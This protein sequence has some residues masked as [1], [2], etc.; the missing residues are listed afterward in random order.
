MAKRGNGE[1]SIYRRADGRWVASLSYVDDAGKRKRCTVYGRTR[2]E[3]SGRLDG[4][5]ER[6]VRGEPLVD[7]AVTVHDWLERWL[8]TSVAASDR[9]PSTVD[10]YRKACHLYI[11]PSL[12][13]RQLGQLKPT[14][15]EHV[16]LALSTRGKSG[17]TRRT[18]YNVLRSALNNG[19][20]DGLVRSN[21]V[22][23]YTGC[24]TQPCRGPDTREPQGSGLL[25]CGLGAPAIGLEP[26]TCRLTAGCSAN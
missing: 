24:Y 19:V 18:A 8:T 6:L 21:V 2:K 1:G 16:L 12:G 5:R 26:I 10:L 22:R 3:V 7:A 9:K 17:P 23:C 11:N 20:R 25:L 15:V 4:L 14:D 13:S